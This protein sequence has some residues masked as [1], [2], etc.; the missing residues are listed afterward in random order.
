MGAPGQDV[1]G[2]DVRCQTHFFRGWGGGGGGVG[3]GEARFGGGG[4]GKSACPTSGPEL[5]GRR[6]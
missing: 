3:V 5:V 4:G 6:I 1:F 2:D